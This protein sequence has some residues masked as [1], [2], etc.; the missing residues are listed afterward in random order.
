MDINLKEIEQLFFEK[1]AEYNENN[2]YRDKIII[3]YNKAIHIFFSK[4]KW[5]YQI[6]D[7]DNSNLWTDENKKSPEKEGFYLCLV[8]WYNSNEYVYFILE[9]KS[10]QWQITD[11]CEHI[12][13]TNL[14]HYPFK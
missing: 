10:S 2:D 14:P 11:S 6:I 1:I 13:W 12:F 9:Y 3:H 7:I 4:A 5:E 8:K